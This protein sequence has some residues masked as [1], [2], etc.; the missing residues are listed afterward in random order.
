MGGGVW[1]IVRTSGK[2]LAATRKSKVRGL[3]Y[4]LGTTPLKRKLFLNLFV[5]LVSRQFI[6]CSRPLVDILARDSFKNSCHLRNDRDEL[7]CVWCKRRGRRGGL[8]VS[9]LDS[10]SSGPGSSPGWGNCVVSLG[11]TQHNASQCLSPPRC[12]NGCRGI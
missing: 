4:L 1:K 11:K 7:Y 9:A 10:G 3:M 5:S 12:I 6:F 8:L 2:M